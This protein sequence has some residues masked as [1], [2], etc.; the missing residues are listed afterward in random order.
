MIYCKVRW[1]LSEEGIKRRLNL[2][3]I[4]NR[5]VSLSP[6]IGEPTLNN[7]INTNESPLS[8][9][10]ELEPAFSKDSSSNSQL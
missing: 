8:I 6:D 7:N 2:K 10:E 1:N 9:A 3:K 4:L 5:G